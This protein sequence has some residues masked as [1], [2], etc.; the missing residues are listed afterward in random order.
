MGISLCPATYY[1]AKIMPTQIN[2]LKSRFSAN[3]KNVC[4][5]SAQINAI[6]FVMRFELVHKLGDGILLLTWQTTA[7]KFPFLL[8]LL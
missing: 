4:K 1:Y 7:P 2:P 5:I 8:P 3:K 6:I